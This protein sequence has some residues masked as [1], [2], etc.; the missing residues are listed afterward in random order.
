MA[1]HVRAVGRG[2]PCICGGMVQI[3]RCPVGHRLREFCLRC[4]RRRPLTL[5]ARHYLAGQ[6][7]LPDVEEL[8]GNDINQ[9]EATPDPHCR[10]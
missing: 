8:Y 1:A 4:G 6:L 3:R 10:R 5:Y 7:T 9:T 2:A